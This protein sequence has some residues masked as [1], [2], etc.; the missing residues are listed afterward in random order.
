M[1]QW[2]LMVLRFRRNKLSMFGLILLVIMYIVIAFANFI[3]PSDPMKQNEDYLYGPPS[4]L[5]LTGPNGEVGLYTYA[6]STELDEETFKFVFTQ[7][8]KIPIKFFVRGDPYKLLG[9]FP[10]DIHLFGVDEPDRIYLLGADSLGRD[11]FTRILVGGQVSLTVGLLGVLLSIVLGSVFGAA[12]GYWGGIIDDIMQRVIEVIQSFPTIPLYAALAAALP[13]TSQNFTMLHRYFLITLILSL[14]NWT[15]LAR[16]LR[17]KV[18]AYRR[19]DFTQAALIAGASDMR[20]IVRHMLPN[21]VSHIVVVAAMAVPGMIMG[22]TALSF[23]G[24]GLA[25][26]MVSWGVL[27]GEAQQVAVIVQHPWLLIPALAVVISV[28]AYSV[29]GDGLRDAVDPYSI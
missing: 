20:I 25:K 18:M 5:S 6:T 24:L 21:A 11:M 9:L 3:G 8:E 7:G 14:I 2:Q 17:G 10:T 13:K 15:G 19:A 12:S 29:L 4:G 22:E 28:L 26:P 16:Q 23:L 27:I 1:S